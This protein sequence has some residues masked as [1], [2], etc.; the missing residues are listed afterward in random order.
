MPS[1][2]KR[3]K[4]SDDNKMMIR[5]NYINITDGLTDTYKIG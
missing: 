5:T 1:V 4:G 2:L 3:K